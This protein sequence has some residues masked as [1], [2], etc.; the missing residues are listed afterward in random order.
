MKK[1]KEKKEKKE[2]PKTARFVD[3]RI[4]TF[5]FDGFNAAELKRHKELVSTHRAIGALELKYKKLLVKCDHQLFY[6]DHAPPWTFRY[7]AICDI[8]LEAI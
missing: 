3:R 8:P 1:K 2:K 7:C 6:D 4:G 5:V